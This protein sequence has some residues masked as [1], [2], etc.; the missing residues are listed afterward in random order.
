M[1]TAKL[2]TLTTTKCCRDEWSKWTRRPTPRPALSPHPSWDGADPRPALPCH[3]TPRETAQ[4]HAP[5][6]LVTPPLVRRRR[7][8]P[9]PALSPHPS[10]DGADPRPALPC[11]P[12]PRETA[13][14]HA[15]PC[16]VTPPLVRRRRPTPRP[17]LSPH[18][19]WDGIVDR[20]RDF[21][22]DKC[23]LTLLLRSF[24]YLIGSRFTMTTNFEI[25][26]LSL[27]IIVTQGN[28]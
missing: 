27:Y 21:H 23:F 2:S 20:G 4:T 26:Y 5:P 3:P 15:P 25:D 9:R 11:H 8:T 7:P 18:P 10:W 16:L 24:S 14:T 28:Y 22:V 1:G 19:S 12:T 13:Q 6:C 17:A